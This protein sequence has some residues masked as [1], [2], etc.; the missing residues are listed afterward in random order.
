MGGHKQ[1]SGLSNC[2]QKDGGSW[3]RPLSSYEEFYVRS[4]ARGA[5]VVAFTL[6][7]TATQKLSEATVTDIFLQL[8]QIVPS[9]QVCIQ[10]HGERLWFRQQNSENLNNLTFHEEPTLE[11]A[12]QHHEKMLH[13]KFS[14]ED[15]LWRLRVVH[16]LQQSPDAQTE[17]K[18]FRTVLVFGFHHA[19]T[20]GTSNFKIA[21]LF[22]SLIENAIQSKLHETQI[23]QFSFHRSIQTELY[24]GWEVAKMLVNPWAKQR[25]IQ[26]IKSSLDFAP[27][28]LDL[29]P[30]GQIDQRTSVVVRHLDEA[31]SS[32]FARRCKQENVTVHSAFSALLNL[33]YAAVIDE[34]G[35]LKDSAEDF[36]INS[37]HVINMRRYWWGDVSSSLGAHVSAYP[38]EQ[39]L[40]ASSFS[41]ERLWS[42]ASELHK[43]SHENIANRGPCRMAAGYFMLLNE[44][45]SRLECE[46]SPVYYYVTSNMGCVDKFFPSTVTKESPGS[47]LQL[48]EILQ[49]SSMKS[50]PYMALFNFHTFRGRFMYM[51]TY[52][53]EWMSDK[54]A[55]DLLESVEKLL[56]VSIK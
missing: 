36:I 23:P 35:L 32:A 12:M 50:A 8:F 43:K 52:S 42:L 14:T 17:R 18:G 22:L 9:L 41:Q 49:S 27:K 1:T 11:L 10:K 48:D 30:S 24:V 6:S 45:Y 31:G 7:I 55:H 20:D 38:L 26:E 51:I 19:I 34:A 33:A 21:G 29:K 37:L 16:V 4:V 46:K 2:F 15:P 3:V 5:D 53:S 40:D 39:T 44:G 56:A 25:M 28:L 47:C 13:Q 54:L